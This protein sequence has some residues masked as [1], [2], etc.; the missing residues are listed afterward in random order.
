MKEFRKNEHGLLICEECK[1]TYKSIRNFS[2]HIK[3]K[4]N[5]YK[6]YFDK[7]LKDENDGICK[8]CGKETEFAGF[9]FHGYKNCCCKE[10]SNKYTYSQ[11]TNSNL[12]NYGVKTQFERP[13]IIEKFENTMLERHGVK[14]ALQN[15]K[16]KKKFIETNKKRYGGNSPL[17]NIDVRKK[18]LK[19]FLKNWG[20]ENPSQ[21][22]E[23]KIKKEETCLKHFGVK[24]PNQSK[25][26]QEKSKQ[27]C[28]K[29]YGFEYPNQNVE[30]FNKGRKTRMQIHPYKNTHLTYQGTFELH[31]IDTY[32]GKIDIE[33]G[34]SVPYFFND[35]WKIYHT[36]YFIPSLNLAIE[37]KNLYLSERDKD[38]IEAKKQGV[39]NNKNKY[40][41]ILII[42]KDYSQFN[43]YLEK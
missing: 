33:N 28:L 17:C 19:T 12:K 7:W 41:Y 18:A 40:K 14:H 3:Y 26:I 27:T 35:M 9:K 32:Y 31:F 4:H 15:K 6:E 23:I 21:S 2:A 29:T 34:I 24:N 10:C 1:A 22:P 37:I 20:V 11:I 42:N 16:F 43:R 30:Q 8:N 36:D 5:M 25:E 39:L 38:E 13:E